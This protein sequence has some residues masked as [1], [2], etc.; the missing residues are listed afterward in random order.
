MRHTRTGLR[1][2]GDVEPS[3]TFPVWRAASLALIAVLIFAPSAQAQQ[4]PTLQASTPQT[5][6][7]SPGDRLS[8]VVFGQTELSGDLVIDVTGNIRLPFVGLI[9]VANLT[10]AECHKHIVDRLADGVLTRPSVNVQ[11]SELRPIYVL[12]DV[13]TAGAH[14]FR[15]GMNIKSAIAVAGGFGVVPPVQGAAVADLLASEERLRQLTL[16]RSILTVRKMRLEAQRDGAKTFPATDQ[17]GER[18]DD[19]LSDIV[20]LE[21]QTFESQMAIQQSQI[22]L[23]RA[24]KPRVESEIEALSGQIAARKK[25]L[26]LVKQQADQYTRLTKQGLGLANTEMQ[27]RLTETTYES[28]IWNLSGQIA[29]LKMDLGTLDLRIQEADAA[30]KRQVLLDLRDVRDRLKD[31]EVTLPTAREIRDAKLQQAGNIGDIRV[32]HTITVTRMRNAQSA[33]F[34]AD[35]TTPLEPG[36]IVEVQLKL[37]R[38]TIA[39]AATRPQVASDDPASQKRASISGATR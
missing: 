22:E 39:D 25:Q 3:S 24:Q 31:L 30:F 15:F 11:I 34:S 6:K 37:S 12:G 23:L 33:S 7:L 29:R 13:R 19:D 14:P 8:V 5:Y 28:E 32:P 10:L 20:A 4:A 18:T 17:T 36:D 2:R 26:D 21:K 38:G 16:Q 35:E 1:T 27:M 9:E